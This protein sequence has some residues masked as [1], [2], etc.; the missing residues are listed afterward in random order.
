MPLRINLVPTSD[1]IS[2]EEYVESIDS[3]GYDFSS[4]ADLIDSARFLQKLSNNRRFLLD[5]M[6][7][8]LKTIGDFQRINYYGPQVCMLHVDERYFVRAN[9]WRPLSQVEKS[10]KGF[11]YDV[12]HD[13]NF[14]ILTIGYF[15]PGYHSRCYTYERR[16]VVGVLGEAVDLRPDGLFTLHE[17][18]I[19]LY[20]AKQD[21]HKQL[22][23]DSMSVSLN[24]IP[25]NNRIRDPQFQFE[26][27]SGQITRY[28]Q[29]SG[30]E[31]VVR[32]AGVLGDARFLEPLETIVKTNPSPQ[33]QA[34]AIVSQ[35]QISDSCAVPKVHSR[36]VRDIIEKELR[37]YGACLR[38]HS[39]AEKVRTE[40]SS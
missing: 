13:H 8:D 38:L 39:I 36:L 25:K 16:N 15:G 19:A 20:R 12:C 22:P 27:D 23:P 32:L 3:Q 33:I 26:E 4:Q 35:L 34:L 1:A 21:V 29:A 6:F 24:L 37:A 5:K 31:L 10:I 11:Q 7:D 40:A 14:D 28:L 18:T 2:L 17:G 30:S 9:I